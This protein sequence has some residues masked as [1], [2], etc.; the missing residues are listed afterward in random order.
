M[1]TLF[2]NNVVTGESRP[3]SIDGASAEERLAKALEMAD[4]EGGS[5]QVIISEHPFDSPSTAAAEAKP[6]AATVLSSAE[7]LAALNLST[8]AIPK[9]ASPTSLPPE[10]SDTLVISINPTSEISVQIGSA[11]TPLSQLPVPPTP[12]F[13]VP[14]YAQFC[15]QWR[16]AGSVIL[17]GPQT[18][19]KEVSYTTGMSTTDSTTLSAELG[20]S[21]GALSAKLSATIGHSITTSQQTTISDTYSI[22]VP[23]GKTSVYILWQLLGSIIFLGADKTPIEWSGVDKIGFVDLRVSFPNPGSGR[24]SQ[25]NTVYSDQTTFNS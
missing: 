13:P 18:Y 14:V 4:A 25:M 16:Q 7:D 17:T 20:V 5:Q 3:L 10:Y 22:D 23:D 1:A 11:W 9:P 6:G 24:I 8:P 15:T 2:M 12:A 19:T 21:Y